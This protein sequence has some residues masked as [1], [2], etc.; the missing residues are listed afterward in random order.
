MTFRTVSSQP[1]E[2][3]RQSTEIPFELLNSVKFYI[4]EPLLTTAFRILT[5]ITTS[6]LAGRKDIYI[7]PPDY[8]AAISTIAVHPS[9]TSRTTDK[10]KHA[11][12]NAAL[13]YLT[14]VNKI[15]GPI[16]AQIST[17]FAFDKYLTLHLT[18]TSSDDA[19]RP[20]NRLSTVFAVEDNIYTTA[21]DFWS[22]V[23]WAFSCSCHA[24][25]SIQ[26]SR[27]RYWHAW[28]E[29]QLTVLGADWLINTS[30]NTA[31]LSLLWSYIRTAS[32]G[33]ARTRRILRA[34]FA[35]ASQRST[36]EF[37][38]IF[39]RELK[40]PRSEAEKQRR[41]EDK[42]RQARVDVDIEQE[43][44]GDYL[45]V[46][47]SGTDSDDQ[48]IKVKA[49]LE[50]DH[51][52]SVKRRR[53]RD[54]ASRRK[55]KHL[56]VSNE[57]E[58]SD[59][60][61]TSKIDHETTLG[62]PEAMALRL[63]LLQLLTD[64]SMHRGPTSQSLKSESQP[65]LPDLHDFMTLLVENIRPL[66]LALFRR[67]IQPHTHS[68]PTLN[69]S[70]RIT[71]NTFLLHR[72]IESD[73]PNLNHNTHSPLEPLTQANLVTVYLPYTAAKNTVE[74]QVKYS[75]LCESLLR[76]LRD[77][78]LLVASPRLVEAVETGIRGRAAK[79][80]EIRSR[81]SRKG[82]EGEEI[83]G[84]AMVVLEGSAARMRAVVERLV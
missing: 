62:P 79:V 17:A 53:L 73:G 59:T 50:M 81:K 49:E 16:N 71:L 4:E 23:G 75:L 3:Y 2:S 36:N 52:R 44:Y 84:K 39:R 25:T 42:M 63:R 51:G 29:Y 74:F 76:H 66:P 69:A 27:W 9:L 48:L 31:H 5:S 21:E 10:E 57:T 82:R 8:L 28:L 11:Q 70:T 18:R 13:K 64:L 14:I 60:S 26:F 30:R 45:D 38:E 40:R 15:V 56:L 34:V 12:A 46:T 78:K 58:D 67:F 43:I 61:A 6:R 54:S 24:S 7:P 77:A 65:M 20:S 37:R 35:D 32:G 55:N 68:T 72:I 22:V 80:D 19:A 47:S 33:D 1:D 41:E 83:E